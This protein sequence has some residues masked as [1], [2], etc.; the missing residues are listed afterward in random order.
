MCTKKHRIMLGIARQNVR[1]L[2]TPLLWHPGR[3]VGTSSGLRCHSHPAAGRQSSPA[4]NAPPFA[5]AAH[6][7]TTVAA[8]LPTA[9]PAARQAPPTQPP[10]QA[11]SCP[12][13]MALHLPRHRPPIPTSQDPA[14]CMKPALVESI[15][16]GRFTSLNVCY[17]KFFTVRNCPIPICRAATSGGSCSS[18]AM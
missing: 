1:L 13:H 18:K 6:V 2:S 10:P 14:Q 17:Y 4:C 7:A 3:A 16:V 12:L 8:A 5:A 11:C 15:Q 9:S